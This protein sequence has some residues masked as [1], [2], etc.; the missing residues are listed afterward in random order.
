[1]SCRP[2]LRQVNSHGTADRRRLNAEPNEACMEVI[3]S[4]EIRASGILKEGGHPYQEKLLVTGKIQYMFVTRLPKRMWLQ[5]R[6]ISSQPKMK[7]A[8]NSI[9]PL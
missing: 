7:P 2:N 5:I 6:V 4:E 9:F 1:M 8:A 3:H